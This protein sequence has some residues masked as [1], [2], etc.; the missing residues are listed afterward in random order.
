MGDCIYDSYSAD[1]FHPTPAGFK[2]RMAQSCSAPIQAWIRDNYGDHEDL[3]DEEAR[4]L[5]LINLRK[6][7]AALGY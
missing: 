5:R 4:K 6:H 1:E 7:K 3:D 2:R